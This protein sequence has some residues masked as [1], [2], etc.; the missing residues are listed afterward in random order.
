MEVNH[1][2]RKPEI[3]MVAE[4]SE[5]HPRNG[6]ADM[7]ELND[8]TIFMSRMEAVRATG[9]RHSADDE[10][11]HDLVSMIS[12]D[13]G[14]TWTDRRI[15]V[16]RGPEDHSMYAPGLVRLRNG[17]ILFRYEVYHRHAYGDL[18]SVSAYACI[19]RDEC[20]TFATPTSLWSRAEGQ[21]GSQGD[22]RQ[23][24]SGRII[25]PML[26]LSDYH[27]QDDDK[28]HCRTGCF[29]S[30]DNGSTWKEG[31]FVDLPMRGT[32]EGK[33][34]ELKDGRLLMVMR[35][36]LGSVFQSI[37]HDGGVIWSKPQTTWLIAPESCPGLTRIPQTSDLLIIWNHSL[38][39]PG[40]DHCGLRSP[41]SVAISKNDGQTW[42]K[43]KDIET[44]PE[45]EFTN[46]TALVTR[47]G[48][49]LIAYEASKYESSSGP[50]HG[51]TR[52]TGRVGR[53]R[54]HLKLAIVDL[55]WLYE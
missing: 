42:E 36:Q 7:I 8:G 51:N 18:M 27:L 6:G 40:F 53:D 41:L 34:E 15:M 16:A 55:E 54:M 38:Y 1:M 37:S 22:L 45:W 26:R 5:A 35:T 25:V 39:D 11:P 4:A 13:G 23:L 24:H 17:E 31:G 50:G 21:A 52:Q 9:L 43:I 49:I 33:I 28:D 30:D 32:M 3:V 14:R 19:S 20:R 10:A 48:D 44:D 2:S 46:P 47:N 29:F 12:R